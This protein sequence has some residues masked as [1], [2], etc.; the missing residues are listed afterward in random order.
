MKISLILTWIH[1]TIQLGDTRT[2]ISVIVGI[3]IISI[4]GF[5]QEVFAA[6][7]ES[8]G[9]GGGNWNNSSTWAGGF[10]PNSTDI[11]IIKS[12]DIVTIPLSILIESGGSITIEGGGQLIIGGTEPTANDDSKGGDNQWDTRPTFG[13]SHETRQDQVVENGF[14][15][16]KEHFTLIDNHHT[17]FVEQSIEI[18]T[19]NSFSAT[20]YA[21]KQ[22][23]VQ[24][25]LFGIPNVGEAQLAELGIE[26]WYDFNGEIED[27]KVVQ[28]SGVIDADTVNVSHD[29]TKCISS[30]TDSKCDTTT[31]SMTFME[32]LKDKV[33]AIKA[34]DWKNRDQRTYLNEGFEISGDSL[35][36]MLTKMIP[37]TLRDEGLLTITQVEK[38][39]PY[40]IAEDGRTFE[41]NSFG[42]FNQINQKFERFEDTGNPYTRVHSGFGEI[43]AYEQKRA[44]Q[45]FDSNEFIS[46]LPESFAYIFPESQRITT[47][48]KTEM[49]KQEAIAKK[50]LD[51][52]KVQARW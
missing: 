1:Y 36:P 43:I 15:F 42:S 28:K 29:K 50:I 26:V 22:L 31:I 23:K 35:N 16:N 37:S 34:I 4:L 2:T 38:Y 47:E 21:A 24:E 40:W 27:V 33:M 3:L 52:S 49:L 30:D 25:F 6:T 18:G 11:V 9:T 32:P 48:M 5:D 12:G 17:D 14:S 51:E 8:N 41:T 19:V 44:T 10:I 7:I 20:V 39:S 46:E 45:L 13:V